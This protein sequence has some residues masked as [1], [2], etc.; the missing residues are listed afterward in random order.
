VEIEKT[1]FKKKK[2]IPRGGN[3]RKKKK[4]KDF[5]V[6]H[7]IP[8][9]LNM[10]M[11]GENLTPAA[12][13]RLLK[14]TKELLDSPPEGVRLVVRGS[15]D[16]SELRAVIVGPKDTPYEGGEF[17][18]QLRFGGEYPSAPPKGVFV[19]QIFHPNVSKAGEICVNTLKRDWKPNLGVAHILLTIKCLLI[20]PNPESALNEEAGMLLLDRYDDYAKRARFMT[21]LY[22]RPAPAVAAPA[23]DGAD[24]ES[25]AA[26]SES[27][28]ESDRTAAGSAKASL[29]AAAAA[30][31]SSSAAAAQAAVA[32]KKSAVADDRKKRALKRL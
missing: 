4:K 32:A 28:A 27:A 9:V 14:E 21:D 13:K 17:V 20:V 26:K 3:K 25:S 18:V 10:T 16:V 23:A 5:F 31:S 30:A 19:T 24:E 29:D 2:K 12:V 22:A 1:H 15:E 11:V 6:V 7:S 8:I